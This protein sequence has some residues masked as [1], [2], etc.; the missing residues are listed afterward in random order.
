MAIVEEKFDDNDLEDFC[1][2]PEPE[3][4]KTSIERIASFIKN[5]SS[6]PATGGESETKKESVVSDGDYDF[7]VKRT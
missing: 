1:T 7:V 3:Q 5:N 6:T 2:P 4:V